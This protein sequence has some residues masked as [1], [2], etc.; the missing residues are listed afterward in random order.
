MFLKTVFSCLLFLLVS[1]S[2]FFVSLS[3]DDSGNNPSTVTDPVVEDPDIEDPD[4]EDP[5]VED[6]DVED[7]DVEDPDVEDPDTEAPKWV[8]RFKVLLSRRMDD[9]GNVIDNIV[10]VQGATADGPSL[11]DQNWK[12]VM[13]EGDCR[14]VEPERFFCEENCGFGYKCVGENTC[15]AE[16]KRINVGK[17]TLS[18]LKTT[19]NT[20]TMS[21]GDRTPYMPIEEMVYPPFED[22]GKITLS[23]AGDS[24]LKIDSFTITGKGIA[25]IEIKNDSIKLEDGKD[26]TLKWE[27]SEQ[28]HDSIF[29]EIDISYHGGT[30]AKILGATKDD[31][32]CTISGEM[33]DK[34][35]AYGI[36]GFPRLVMYRRAT[37]K[38]KAGNVEL[39]IESE[40][41][42]YLHVP[43]IIS[44]NGY[45][46]DGMTCG[47][48]RVCR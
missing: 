26:I 30:K 36:A 11:S 9:L 38:N 29:F 3:C 34:L 27:P 15:Q 14:L 44:C 7:P 33:L 24:A 18:G 25:P 48:D 43:G 17:V 21:L 23:F 37:F 35:K 42:K 12:T 2:L 10:Q 19:E 45:C 32:S 4:V 20:T 41:M 8:G 28:D 13:T 1:V 39:V 6:P 40:E 16:P 46:P 47:S 22:G 5:D 31:G